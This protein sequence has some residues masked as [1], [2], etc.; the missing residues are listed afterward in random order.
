MKNTVGNRT[1]YQLFRKRINNL[2]FP[3]LIKPD[4]RIMPMNSL[5]FQ[6]HVSGSCPNPKCTGAEIT[7]FAFACWKC[8]VGFA[9][10]YG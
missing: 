8:G 1:N 2:N 3:N 6:R 5:Y 7:P 10:Y 9:Q 4:K